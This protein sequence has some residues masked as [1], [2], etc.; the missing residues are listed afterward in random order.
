MT[1]PLPAIAMTITQAGINAAIAAGENGLKVE[2]TEIALGLG[3]DDG[4]GGYQGYEITGNET[5]L[6]NTAITAPI[7]GGTKSVDG[8]VVTAEF[9]PTENINVRSVAA[10]MDGGV[11][12]A[13][14]SST[15]NA[16]AQLSPNIVF[17]Q[18][19]GTKLTRVNP[20]NIVF[21]TTNDGNLKH[22]GSVVATA[23]IDFGS[24]KA[25]NVADPAQN[26]D[27]VNKQTLDGEVQTL[28]QIDLLQHQ[29]IQVLEN[30]APASGAFT[31]Y[32]MR[33]VDDTDVDIVAHH[34][35]WI[36]CD[37]STAVIDIEMPDVNFEGVDFVIQ[38]K[39]AE[40]IDVDRNGNNINDM[41]ENLEFDFDGGIVRF[42]G[43]SA[44]NWQAILI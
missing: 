16:L 15:T 13:I 42:I 39:G 7:T 3:E 26:K 35:D 8:F 30:A 20:E 9:T 11:P 40:K 38:R 25:R 22:D 41:A 17:V 29:R 43:K 21:V 31:K 5:E 4:N 2:I 32:T 23:D 27:A 19:I 12:F 36:I 28:Q 10:L 44:T 37:T 14:W 33:N 6:I 18:H 24:H 34:G 1:E